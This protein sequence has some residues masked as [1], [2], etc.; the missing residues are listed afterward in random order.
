MAGIRARQTLLV[1]IYTLS[2]WM[3]VLSILTDRLLFG[4]LGMPFFLFLVSTIHEAGH[5]LGCRINKNTVTGFRTPVFSVQ[6]GHFR[7][8]DRLFP[9]GGCS[10]LKKQQDGLVYLCGPFASGFCFILCLIWWLIKPGSVALLCMAA[11]GTHVLVNIFPCRRNDLYYFIKELK[12][13]AP[14]L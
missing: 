5:V 4:L 1:L 14:R 9:G 6:G 8:N 2:G 12:K 10:F 3:F 11:A 13:G 7:I